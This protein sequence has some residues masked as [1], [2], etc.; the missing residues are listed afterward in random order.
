MNPGAH[1]GCRSHVKHL[2][3]PVDSDLLLDWLGPAKVQS[4]AT[5]VH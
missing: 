3:C 5:V 4:H 2:A 1:A